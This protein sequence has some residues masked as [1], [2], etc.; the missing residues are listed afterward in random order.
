M[1]WR[2]AIKLL[3]FSLIVVAIIGYGFMPKPIPVDIAP[4]TRDHL[5][6]IL[7]T[8]GKTRV[9]D[10]FVVSAPI[11]GFLQ[12]ILLKV[13][14]NVKAGQVITQLEPLRARTLDPRS[15]AQA[16]AQVSSAQAALRAAQENVKAAVADA[17][18]AILEVKRLKRLQQSGSI[19][20]DTLDQA[21][22]R[23]RRTQ[24]SRRSAEFAVKVA[25]FELEAARTALRYSAAAKDLPTPLEKLA[26]TAPVQGRVLK[27]Q[28]QSEAIVSAGQA[29]IEIGDPRA[30]EVEIEV[31]SPDAVRIKPG[32]RV[33]FE[34]WGGDAPLE[35]RVRRIEPV[36]FTKISAL[37]VEEQRVLIIA[38]FV[39]VPETWERLGDRYRVEAQ[40]ILWEG[41][42]VLQ[43]PANALFRYENGW[44]VF[45]VVGDTVR[46]R[47][48]VVGHRSGLVAEVVEGLKVGEVVVTHPSDEVGEGV[49]VVER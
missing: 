13:G 2:R 34:R 16:E 43:I 25:Q 5:Q 39:S 23:A 21:E 12:R 47:K 32:S 18:Y 44:A 9:I 3:L 41:N 1:P 10:R 37:G 38:D 49:K 28:Q 22:A 30:L 46:R 7:E 40:F 31:L 6:V 26:I 24:A 33:L 19:A 15:R 8:E 4:V 20:K 27:L 14:D 42:E 36:A 45:T 48:V 17:D 29:L 35:G 11:D